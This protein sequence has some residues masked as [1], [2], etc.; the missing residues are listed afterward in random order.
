MADQ[1]LRGLDAANPLA[2]L[3]A[4]GVLRVLSATVPRHI[5]RPRMAWQV[6][7]GAWRPWMTGVPAA[8]THSFAFKID[9]ACRELKTEQAIP[10]SDDLNV[11]TKD[12]RAFARAA[13][14]AAIARLPV[15]AEFAAALA[16][17]APENDDG[18]V[19]DTALRTMSGAGHQHF[20]KTMRNLVSD[21]TPDHIHK[22][23]FQV[24]DHDDPMRNMS[25]RWDPS[26]DNR[27]ALRWSDPSGD[28]SRQVRG[29]MWGAN[30]LAIEALPLLPVMPTSGQLETVGF[31]TAGARGTF[32]TWPVWEPPLDID[33]VR[34]LLALA[35]LQQDVLARSALQARGVG[36][37][38]RS[39]RLTVGKFRNFTWGTSA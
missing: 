32:W 12:Y 14:D 33:T 25:L 9:A 17:D 23:L 20:L 36:E 6:E 10:P 4:M 15:P 5:E 13:A 16:C 21:T 27:Y 34:S 24:W 39:Q 8:D 19:Q 1:L 31:R 11:P 18:S 29:A 35:E 26:D 22:A 28:P 37:V 2:Y 7:A 38:F 3:A 30:R